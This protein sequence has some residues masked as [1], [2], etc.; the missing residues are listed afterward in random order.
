MN[1]MRLSPKITKPVLHLDFADA[2]GKGMKNDNFIHNLLA[3][4]YEVKIVD[5]P[6]VLIFTHYGH[7][8]RLYSCKK[9]FYTQERYLP[10]WKQC[11]AA[12]TSAYM[13]H[14]RAYYYPFFA[15]HRRGEDLVRPA[16]FD[17]Q[18]I[19]NEHRGFCSF[20]HKYADHSV[21][22]RTE[23]FHELNR[24]K[25]VDSGGLAFN[26]VGFEVPGTAGRAKI[27]FISRYRF[28]IAFENRLSPGWTTEKFTDAFEAFTVPIYWGDEHALQWFNPKSF[29]NVRDYR[30][31]SECFDYILHLENSPAEYAKMLAEPPLKDNQVPAIYSQDKLLEFLVR[32]I[33]RQEI[34]IAR[35]RWFWPITRIRLVKR[36]RVHGE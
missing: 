13:N 9:I 24:R 8:N 34:P 25:K 7:R 33:D 28:H 23:F 2:L 29:I 27:D 11:D 5:D 4:H 22:P 10:D 15:A 26:N 21:R 14:P 20:L 36:D 19:L 31:I 18:R 12:V 17:C 35:R 30:N 32:E 16:N 1:Y 6:D 3:R